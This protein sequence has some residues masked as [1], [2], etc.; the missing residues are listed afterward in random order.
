MNYALAL[1]QGGGHEPWLTFKPLKEL[2]SR[3][4]GVLSG[5]VGMGM[6]SPDRV[7]FWPLKFT[8]DPFLFE[9]LFRYRSHCCKMLKGTGHDF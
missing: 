5:K 7:P 2:S 9:N 4:G 6:C 3:G 1:F 8:I